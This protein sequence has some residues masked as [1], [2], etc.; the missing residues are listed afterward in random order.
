[1]DWRPGPGN[2]SQK[3]AKICP[4][5][6]VAHKKPQKQVKKINKSKL[7]DFPNPYMVWTDL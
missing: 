1:L 4:H 3:G 2:I 5:Y 7:E 6:D